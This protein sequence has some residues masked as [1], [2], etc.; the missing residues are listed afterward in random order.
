MLV[1]SVSIAQTP[2]LDRNRSSLTE[3]LLGLDPQIIKA[4]LS[5]CQVC[6][7]EQ[8]ETGEPDIRLIVW[9]DT[10]SEIH[11]T[12]SYHKRLNIIFGQ[13]QETDLSEL[14][15]Y[16]G[17]L[18]KTL[19]ADESRYW[20]WRDY[21]FSITNPDTGNHNQWPVVYDLHSSNLQDDF[22]TYLV[23]YLD[24]SYLE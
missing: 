1:A 9:T 7:I 10:E 2:H 14:N 11:Y 17:T 4:E 19:Q 5:K 20:M 12:I 16:I 22:R 6:E 3:H 8:V 23:I 15:N 24:L 18:S 21:S 13:T